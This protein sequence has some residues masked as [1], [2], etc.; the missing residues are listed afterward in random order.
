MVKNGV[1]KIKGCSKKVYSNS[2]ASEKFLSKK[3]LD[4][5]NLPDKAR[6]PEF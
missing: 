6:N 2:L 1:C 3:F 5:S 4:L